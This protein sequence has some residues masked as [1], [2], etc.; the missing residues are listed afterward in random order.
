MR[1]GLLLSLFVVLVLP[2]LALAQAAETAG[3]ITE[4]KP[5]R[6]RVEV[7][8][9]GGT[10]WRLARPLLALR[11]GDT[12]RTTD[13]AVTVVLLSGGR[14]TTRVAG[15]GSSFT[16]PAAVAG[17]GQGRKA[18]ALVQ[19]SLGYLAGTTKESSQAAL[20]TRSGGRP[21][22][23]IGPRNG[24]VLPEAL[25]FE[26]LGSRFTKYTVRVVDPAGSVVTRR[27]VTGARWDYP[28]DAPALS[29]G[30]RYTLQVSAPGQPAQEAWFEVV[31]AARARAVAAD[32]AALEQEMG[33]GVGPTSRAVLRAGLLA[34]QELLD[35]ARRV[36]VAALAQ[37]RDEPTLHLL[38]GD[39]YTRT[40]LPDLAAESFDEAR[41]LLN[42]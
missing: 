37:D 25:A 26:W 12:V 20:A 28:A 41:F 3:V 14:G 27:E 40:G 17:A 22:V 16:V 10:D 8:A 35:D 9:A 1:A 15:A 32:L 24:R 18:R 34:Q 33:P 31:D 23:I 4:I 13:D 2:A 11:A 21:P 42:K 7:Q 38:L 30:L 39:L 19:A 5:G 36:V 6:G 29:A